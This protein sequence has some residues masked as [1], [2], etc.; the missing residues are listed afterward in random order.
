MCLFGWE[1]LVSLLLALY[2]LGRNWDVNVSKVERLK[3]IERPVYYSTP[4]GLEIF[5]SFRGDMTYGSQ[6]SGYCVVVVESVIGFLYA[7]ACGAWSSYLCTDDIPQEFSKGLVFSPH[8]QP[9]WNFR[10]ESVRNVNALS[11][12]SVSHLLPR[13]SH[14]HTHRGLVVDSHPS[15]G[16][17]FSKDGERDTLYEIHPQSCYAVIIFDPEPKRKLSKPLDTSR[18]NCQKGGKNWSFQSEHILNV[19]IGFDRSG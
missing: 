15:F 1:I 6:I 12:P 3:D 18:G 5:S 11:I 9:G 10:F 19:S 2:E 17:F 4:T 16:Y 13:P 8:T 14:T 7:V